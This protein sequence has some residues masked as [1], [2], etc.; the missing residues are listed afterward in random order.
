MPKKGFKHSEESKRKMSETR[1]NKRTIP[2]NKGLTKENSLGI[3]RQALAISG[4][5]NSSKRPEVRAKQSACKKGLRNPIAKKCL[6]A[7]I[8][9][10]S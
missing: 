1:K 9:S 7:I 4:E 2:W 3:A 6:R 5:R 8:E 10:W